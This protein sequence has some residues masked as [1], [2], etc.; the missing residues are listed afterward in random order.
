MTGSVSTTRCCNS[1]PISTAAFFR[2]LSASCPCW[3]RLPRIR[4]SWISLASGRGPSPNASVIRA[5]SK[6]NQLLLLK[7]CLKFAWLPGLLSCTYGRP[8]TVRRSQEDQCDEARQLYPGNALGQFLE[9]PWQHQCSLA[10]VLAFQDSDPTARL[11]WLDLQDSHLSPLGHHEQ[12]LRCNQERQT[13]IVIRRIELFSFCSGLF[14]HGH[15]R[16]CKFPVSAQLCHAAHLRSRGR[17]LRGRHEPLGL[18]HRADEPVAAL[19]KRLDE[20][21]LLIIVAQRLA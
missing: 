16:K 2:N 7:F 20:T 14:I 5:S 9:I 21:R 4:N 12:P 10:V 1:N 8:P 3:I 18:L 17:I 15:Q 19:R 11:R 6:P 13:H